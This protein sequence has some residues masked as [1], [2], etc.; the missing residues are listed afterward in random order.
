MRA[1]AI[2]GAAYALMFILTFGYSFNLFYTSNDAHPM[3][4]ENR[5]IESFICGI[6]WPLFWSSEAFRYLRKP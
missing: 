6:A 1:W 2:T 5:C 3:A 4:S